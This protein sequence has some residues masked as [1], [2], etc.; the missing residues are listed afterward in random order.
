MHLHPAT[1]CSSRAGPSVKDARRRV[2]GRAGARH[3]PGFARAER[4][5]AAGRKCPSKRFVSSTCARAR[6]REARRALSSLARQAGPVDRGLPA[7][8]FIGLPAGAVALP[9]GAD[10]PDELEPCWEQRVPADAS[11][12][13]KTI[14]ERLPQGLEDGAGK[15]REL[16]HKQN[17]RCASVQKCLLTVSVTRRS[18][19]PTRPP[20]PGSAQS[21]RAARVR[22]PVPHRQRREPP[23]LRDPW[24]TRS[25]LGAPPPPEHPRAGRARSTSPA[26]RAIVAS[27]ANA[28]ITPLR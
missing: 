6:R 2:R 25:A 11:N 21:P 19:E 22:T 3:S 10:G 20:R 13:N 4:A 23:K 5:R 12:R 9:R 18:R 26:V 24:P 7:S 17:P 8:Q 16:V 14:L 15:L 28:P 27:V 1:A